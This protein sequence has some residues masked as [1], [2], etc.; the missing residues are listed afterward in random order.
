MSVRFILGRA[1]TGKTERCFTRIVQEMRANPLGPAIFWVVPKQATFALER[2]LTTE[3]G[4]GGF[5]RTRVV[6]FELLG[7]QILDECG[8]TAV[9]EITAYGRQMI[10]G[11]LLRQNQPKLHFFST[12]ARQTGLAIKLDATFAELERCGKVPADLAELA[13]G[14]ESADSDV[15]DSQSLAAKLHDLQLI[16]NAYSNYLGQDRLDP[17]RRLQQVLASVASCSMLRGASVYI[18]GFLDFTEYER[19]VLVGMA[20]VCK[21]LEITLL[22]DPASPA[23]RNPHILPEDLSLFHRTEDAYRRLYFALTGENVT[24]DEPVL[25]HIPHRYIAGGLKRLE[26]DLFVPASRWRKDRQTH[27]EAIELIE[28]PSRRAEADAVASRVREL[29]MEGYRLRDIAV[30]V[31]E[32]DPYM[33]LLAASFQEHDLPCFLDRRRSAGHHPV[34]QFLR[35][36]LQSTI[37]PFAHDA[38]MTLLKTGLADLNAEEADE[39]ENYV[40]M[41]RV[42]GGIWGLKESWHAR[43]IKTLAEDEELGPQEIIEVQDADRLRRRV[44]NR[45]SPFIERVGTGAP[46]SVREVVLELFRMFESFGVRKKLVEWMD[47]AEAAGEIEQRAEHEQVWAELVELFDQMCDLLGDEQVTAGDFVEILESGLETFDLGLA[48]PTVDQVLIGQVD[49]TRNPH[50]RA[51]LVM[52]MNDG[53][54]PRVSREDSVLNDAERRELRARQIETEPDSVRRQLDESLLG[55]I[56]FT[57]ASER[58]IVT[59]SMSDDKGE[60]LGAS[61]FWQE[62]RA[63]CPNATVTALA[64]DSENNMALL[65]T[66]RR[67]VTSLMDWVRTGSPAGDGTQAALYAWLAA[68]EPRS[69]AVDTMRFRAWRALSYINDASLSKGV[70][71]K[72]F[73]TS[74]TASASQMETFASCPFKHFVR[75]G[76][77]L[78][79]RAEEDP[80]AMDL[81][82]VY[83]ETLD[84][85]VKS[86]LERKLDWTQLSEEKAR[87]LIDQCASEVGKTLREELMLSSARNRYLL[88]R[89]RRTIEKVAAAQKAMAV[90]GGFRPAYAELTFGYDDAGLPPL[91]IQTPEGHELKLRGKIDRVDL[92]R[93]D[94][95]FS[96][97]DYKLSDR[98]INFDELRHGIALQLLT[99]LLVL[100]AHGEKLTG[101]KMTPAAAFYVKLLRGLAAVDHPSEGLEPNAPEFHL[102]H[103]PRGILDSGFATAFDSELKAG[104]KSDVIEAYLKKDNTF[105]TGR[106][107]DCASADELW[108]L[109]TH[110]QYRM[111][112]LADQILQGNVSIRPYKLGG[113]SACVNCDYRSICRFHVK[114]NR[115]LQVTT[116]GRDQT[117][118]WIAG[119]GEHGE[120]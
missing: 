82:M 68:H 86:V 39:L 41:H 24:T 73:G 91:V 32:P 96:V 109:M 70:R 110:V 78:Q 98:R 6:S 27:D 21:D 77:R 49:R 112:Q 13:N 89:I 2:R 44:V 104:S 95:A 87:E 22:I 94:Q 64:R 117:L 71:E 42:R 25:L 40:L 102:K 3:S 38:M 59:R 65:S 28:A 103:K 106:G 55:Y 57:Q 43:R 80:T 46:L 74:L 8:G 88:N 85:L 45:L 83:H 1:G 52:G 101:K 36:A 75:Y 58:L 14:F 116:M 31:R 120:E 79:P 16:Y 50:V 53:V 29:L 19:Q 90:R 12:V 111:G 60:P 23:L 67:L 113:T 15:S 92:L 30:L 93:D 11:L 84:R 4:L 34:L 20:K 118:A 33:E 9:P 47:D 66:P 99:Y 108:M 115:Y 51:V 72:L 76:L 26:R 7:R 37:H 69:D 105:S 18:D 100:D 56:A 17:H 10:L 62:L 35:S 114:T 63:I 81:G 107:S 97:I 5:C 61:V 48:P 119:G 54:F